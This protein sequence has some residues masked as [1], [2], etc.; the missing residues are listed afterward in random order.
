[1][2]R[3]VP[4]QGISKR[5]LCGF[6]FIFHSYS[7]NTAVSVIYCCCIR[8][9]VSL[10]TRISRT[11]QCSFRKSSKLVVNSFWNPT[12]MPINQG[13][14][15]IIN[16]FMRKLYDYCI[17]TELYPGGVTSTDQPG[18]RSPRALP[19]KS[20]FS[21]LAGHAKHRRSV[22]AGVRFSCC[23]AAAYDIEG[24]TDDN[25]CPSGAAVPDGCPAPGSAPGTEG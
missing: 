2:F 15:G 7:V 3:Y 6:I 5:R 18:T 12:N 4:R 21:F 14:F 25:I 10:L 16:W 13:F 24:C 22:T 23:S 11:Y 1:M 17:H 19:A 20:E 9:W 8:I